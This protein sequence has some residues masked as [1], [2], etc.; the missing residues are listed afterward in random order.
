MTKLSEKK[1]LEIHEAT[2]EVVAAVDNDFDPAE[3][4]NN[5]DIDDPSELVQIS[6]SEAED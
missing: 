6:E 5:S 4:G 3:D 2:Q 1:W